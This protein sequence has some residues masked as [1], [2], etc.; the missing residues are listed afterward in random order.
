MAARCRAKSKALT[1]AAAQLPLIVN[2]QSVISRCCA[3]PP[4]LR[5]QTAE[6]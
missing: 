4:S 1:T 5:S 2:K 6:Q 3:P